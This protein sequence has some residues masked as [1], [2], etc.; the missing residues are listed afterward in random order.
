MKYSIDKDYAL[1]S[2]LK[3]SYKTERKV[4][5]RNRILGNAR[6]TKVA[7]DIEVTNLQMTS[8]DG[9]PL[10]LYLYRPKGFDGPLPC[11]VYYHG[12]GFFFKGDFT[13][14]HVISEYCRSAKIAVLYVDY[15]VSIDYP[16]P[17]PTEDCYAAISWAYKHAKDISID[18]QK[19]F[20]CGFSAGGA[21]A[22]GVSLMARNRMNPPIQLQIL[23][24]PVIDH[25]QITPSAI[26]YVDTPNWNSISNKYMWEVYLRDIKYEVP[27][28]ASP[29]VAKSLK[30]L[31]PSFIEVSEFDP[32]H[33]EG[34]N[35]A[36]RLKKSE[37]EVLLNETKGTLHLSSMVL[38]AKQ[39]I[40]SIRKITNFIASHI[41]Y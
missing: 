10:E 29:A 37:V 2:L 5:L 15:R 19:I 36:N 4:R 12:G 25:R 8:F 21:L 1:L 16:Y 22:A 26:Q 23:I 3:T 13:T 32:L 31:P 40:E 24:S 20:V 38:T 14:I 41:D 30:N 35:Y 18:P 33:D 28:Y 9:Y 27:C 7:D 34:V 39:S 17:I 6:M 11:M